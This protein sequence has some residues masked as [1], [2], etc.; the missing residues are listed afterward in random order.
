MDLFTL[1]PCKYKHDPD[2]IVKGFINSRP[3]DDFSMWR[4]T[5]RDNLSAALGL[6]K[7]KIIAAYDVNEGASCVT[8]IEI[9]KWRVEGF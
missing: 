9:E 5:F 6:S 7:G 2:L 3:P 1:N 4:N 8:E